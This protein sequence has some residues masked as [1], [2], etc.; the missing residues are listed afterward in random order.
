MPPRRP[1]IMRRRRRWQHNMM[2][3]IVS[4]LALPQQRSGVIKPHLLRGFVRAFQLEIPHYLAKPGRLDVVNGITHRS[5]TALSS[6]VNPANNNNDN[7]QAAAEAEA[8]ALANLEQTRAALQRALAEL[9]QIH[10]YQMAGRDA[11]EVGEDG[12]STTS[13]AGSASGGQAGVQ[14]PSA[15]GNTKPQQQL[16]QPH[17][18][19]P[20]APTAEA[21]RRR[22]DEQVQRQLQRRAEAM[23]RKASAVREVQQRRQSWQSG[24]TAARQ[25]AQGHHPN[26]MYPYA[27]DGVGSASG[28]VQSPSPS[29]QR[30]QQ[31][32]PFQQPQPQSSQVMS[33]QAQY[34]DN[35]SPDRRFQTINAATSIPSNYN[36]NEAAQP[37]PQMNFGGYG[38]QPQYG[39]Q[40]QVGYG[41]G[42]QQQQ[43]FA[44]PPMPMQSGPY[45]GGGYPQNQQYPSWAQST[46]AP[47]SPSSEQAQRSATASPINANPT[48]PPQQTG[49]NPRPDGRA[50][51]DA[52]RAAQSMRDETTGRPVSSSSSTASP[53][54]VEERRAQKVREAQSAFRNA[55]SRDRFEAGDVGRYRRY[56]ADYGMGGSG[57]A[58]GMGTGYGGQQMPI[59]QSMGYGGGGS[60][61]YSMSGPFGDASSYVG[62]MEGQQF[63]QYSQGP[64]V[65]G[66]SVPPG[67][68]GSQ[69]F[70]R[71][72]MYGSGASGSA[73]MGFGG[74]Y[75]YGGGSYGYGG[76]SW[77]GQQQGDEFVE[78]VRMA[79][80]QR[81][82]EKKMKRQYLDEARRSQ[83]QRLQ[84]P[85]SGNM[86]QE[87]LQPPQSPPAQ[88]QP[89][90]QPTQPQQPPSQ[91]AKPAPATPQK[92][93]SNS[94][95]D[96]IS[97]PA[98]Q[99]PANP[100]TPIPQQTSTQDVYPGNGGPYPMPPPFQSGIQRW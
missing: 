78:H 65:G 77:G 79:E 70:G 64:Y 42:Q 76:Q 48:M 31:R 54:T 5:Q 100:A 24:Q 15:A 4:S 28:R 38:R 29:Q 51:T 97:A 56:A 22:Q 74:G 91:P 36:L 82:Y 62:G 41:Y 68:F 19:N 44:Q 11:S 93:G 18:R 10:Q 59:Q 71:Q 34:Q 14:A 43:Q 46:V 89:P 94:Y 75:G 88:G 2:G 63:G 92:A 52:Q 85:P 72:S 13:S 66:F 83:Q 55:A 30:Q 8:E 6:Q 45:G 9:D 23:Q 39:Q 80:Q 1:K 49:Y 50:M 33:G 27:T 3:W 99:S 60:P 69:S 26:N 84:L 37:S 7:P 17:V 61:R 87:Q 25:G 98:N 21:E 53:G 95:L 32:G 40:P 73:M 16:Q 86:P 67:T 57:M 58:V 12:R 20:Q 96:S 81:D 35:L 90:T 47:W